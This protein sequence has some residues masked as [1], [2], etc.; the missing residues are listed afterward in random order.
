[1]KKIITLLL[2]MAALAL[3]YMNVYAD[4]TE[5]L[6]VD[7]ASYDGS[8]LLCA[9]DGPLYTSL[10]V[11]FKPD[12]S[13][14]RCAYSI[15]IDDGTNFGGY[16]D[17]EGES[18]TLFPDDDTAPNNRWQIKFKSS[19][20]EGGECESPIYRIIFDTQSPVIGFEDEAVTRWLTKEESVHLS[21]SDQISG[22]GRIIT[23][24]N[25]ELVGEDHY[26]TGDIKKEQKVAV[27]LK[28]TGKVYNKV[29]V[30]CFDLAGNSAVFSFEYRFDTSLPRLSVQGIDNADKLSHTGILEL[31]AKDD[32][33]EVYIDYII[34]RYSGDEL[35]TTEGENMPT[36]TKLS[37]DRDGKYTVSV[38]ATDG[39][40]NRS[41]E[42]RREFT[43]DQTSPSVEIGGVSESADHTGNVTVT[44]DV[45]EDLYEDCLVDIKLTRSTMD[46][47][48]IIPIN[49]YTLNAKRDTRGVDI[50]SDGEYSIEVAATD[51]AGN[52]TVSS[53][54]FRI[55]ATAPQIAVSGINEGQVTS[56]K[57]KLRFD[58]AELFYGSTIMKSV[59]S[60]A[61]NGVYV[62]VKTQEHVMKSV[63]DS[64]E[65]CP[66]EEGRYRLICTASDRSGN[67]SEKT[68]DFAIDYTPPVI[69]GLSE[70]NNRYFK[71]FALPGKVAD[72]VKDAFGV[73]AGAFVNDSKFGDNDVI[74]EEGKYVLSIF[75]EDMAGNSAEDQAVFIVDHTSPQ[76]VLSGFDKNGGVQKGSIVKV[77]LL[78]DCDTLKSVYFN[79]KSIPV[80]A[81]NTATVAINEYG[82]YELDI[83]AEDPAGNVTD[84]TVHTS[85]YM[86]AGLLS[87]LIKSEKNHTSQIVK[88]DK[89][90]PDVAGLAIGLISV[91]SGTYGLTYRAS[92]RH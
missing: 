16:A 33:D 49:S 8:T 41:K 81:D 6:A 32:S 53:K 9:G 28:D 74:I 57:P 61:N 42:E 59:L 36:G 83:K 46:K 40:G 78:E 11:S 58:A 79:G 77:G 38:W 18:I 72:F 5:T 23:R 60:K 44:V 30:E 45:A 43:I 56:D 68:V 82:E 20:D 13:K 31:D 39:A 4:E 64:I 34:Q 10:P 24:C 27:D 1:M 84:T 19:N 70:I 3:P 47:S 2:T 15:S 29:E 75:A 22:I 37:F 92:L 50:N 17:M 86:N 12:G 90:E 67:S 76:I 54:S 51:G 35:I 88:N 25:G 66:E 89:N 14:G 91:L 87:G 71:S 73:K 85:A 52:R 21:I 55:D 48:E 69:S 65:I 62:P 80:S 7:I 26:R 63:Q